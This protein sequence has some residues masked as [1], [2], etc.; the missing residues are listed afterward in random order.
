DDSIW[1]D[2]GLNDDD[3]SP[4]APPW[5]SD[6]QV[7]AGIHGILLRDRCDEEQRRLRYERLALKEW[8]GE[9]WRVLL[10]TIDDL[11]ESEDDVLYQLQ[12]RRLELCKLCMV[13]DRTLSVLPLDPTLPPWGPTE[14]E[15]ATTALELDSDSVVSDQEYVD[16][17]ASDDEVLDDDVDV[18][19][20]E[21]IDLLNLT[22]GWNAGTQEIVD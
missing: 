5:Q 13:W 4:D 18:G 3:D 16:E 9:E 19:L 1:D 17:E 7:R 2:I 10:R 20:I 8:F 12:R 22:D 21:S 6:D 11:H 15:L 14:L